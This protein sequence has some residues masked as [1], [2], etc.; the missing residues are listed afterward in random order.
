MKRVAY[1]LA[2]PGL[3]VTLTIYSHVSRQRKSM[4]ISASRQVRFR[5]DPPWLHAPHQQLA[6]ALGNVAGLHVH[7]H[8]SCVHHCVRHPGLL[9][10]DVSDALGGA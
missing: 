4:L 5:P 6:R 9:P 1:G 10:D 7:L 2:I 8:G 3:F